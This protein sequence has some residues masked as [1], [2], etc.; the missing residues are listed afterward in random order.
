V[1][2]ENQEPR[3]RVEDRRLITGAGNYVDDIKFKNQA[4]LGIVR[5]P[6]PHAK[7]KK[8]DFTEARKSPDFIASLTGE[9]LLNLGVSPSVQF[10]MQKPANRYQL[11][12]GKTIFVGEAVAALVARNRY[13][14]EDLID[15][16]EVEYEELSAV[17]T[18][19]Q[20]KKKSEPLIFESWKDN[21]ALATEAKR[22]DADEALRSSASV[23]KVTLGIHRQAGTPIEPRAVSVRYDREKDIFEVHGTV[24][25]ANRLQAYLSQELKLPKEKFHVI[26]KDVGGGFGTKGA[27]SY[28]EPALACIFSHATGL[29]VKWTSTRTEDF[30]ETAPGRDEFCDLELGC[31]SQGRLTALKTTIEMDIGVSG[32]LSAMAMLTQRLIPGAYPIPNISVKASAYVTNKPASGPVRGAG[33]P[34]AC[35]FIE[36]AIDLM[37]KKLGVEPL[38]FRRRNILQPKDFPYDNGT[39][40]TYDSANFPLLLDTLEKDGKYRAEVEWRDKFNES[41]GRTYSTRI[42]GVGICAEIEDTGSQFSETA[43]LVLNSGGDLL[44]YTGSSPHGQGLETT[45]AQL[46]SEELNVPIS[47]IQVV[48]GDTDLVPS[49]VGTFGSRSIAAGGSAAV[50]A[51]RKFKAQLTESLKAAG[52]SE[53]QIS[54]KGDM[55]LTPEGNKIRIRDL[56]EKLGIKELS[57]STEY[58]MSQSTFASGV[59]LCSLILDRDTGKIAIRKYI[60]I[61]DVGRVINSMIVDGQIEGGVIHGLG[62]SIYEELDYDEDGRPLTTTFMDYLVPSAMESPTVTVFHVE[63]PSTITL[64]GARGAGEAGTVAAYPAIFNALNDAIRRAGGEDLNFA[65]AS[66]ERILKISFH[67]RLIPAEASTSS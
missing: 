57:V 43:R 30:L 62:G 52:V 12:V 47:Q 13:A 56:F 15:D 8:I 53:N 22:G 32:T 50:D 36:R 20:A 65:P 9:E 26:V 64:D 45:L 16:V 44:L 25:S 51:A 46:V 7:I 38:E 37:A 66:P 29:P 2:D 63:T 6:Y 24:Q 59:H 39:G 34:E 11:A 60:A 49:G 41:S 61:D 55:L 1:T 67:D 27:Q 10:P 3:G 28:P 14:V 23:V 35:F 4:Y 18:I 58:R 5:S 31:D 40:F 17:V 21:L 42:A 54:L 48:Y 19:D 33:R